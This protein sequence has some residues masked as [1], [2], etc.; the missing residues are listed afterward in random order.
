MDEG[1]P[2][3]L[4]QF[5]SILTGIV[6]HISIQNDFRTIALGPVHLDQRR[7]RRHNDRCLAAECICRISHTLGMVS[8]GGRDQPPAPLFFGKRAD[9]VVGAP[10]LISSGVLHIFRF[11]VHP[12]ACHFTQIITV[13]Q[14][15]GTGDPLHHFRG[16]FKFFQCHHSGT[17]LS[18]LL[19]LPSLSAPPCRTK[20]SQIHPRQISAG[21]QWTPRRRYISPEYPAPP[22]LPRR[23]RPLPFRPSWSGSL[24]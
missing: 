12:S 8:G 7:H 20:H 1:I 19:N 5:C 14:L 22:G 17:L 10:Q 6:V 9:L 11:Q 15:G 4:G 3:F 21:R 24:R 2:F 13:Y 16:I 18:F 23:F